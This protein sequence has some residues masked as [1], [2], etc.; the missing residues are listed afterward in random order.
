MSSNDC[1]NNT[2]GD[3]S[4][5]LVID[6]NNNNQQILN[7][8]DNKLY[9]SLCI[10]FGILMAAVSFG[11]GYTSVGVCGLLL[12]IGGFVWYGILDSNNNKLRAKMRADIA[13]NTPGP[14]VPL[15]FRQIGCLATPHPSATPSPQLLAAIASATLPPS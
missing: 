12:F 1:S 6:F 11:N 4:N 5:N 14:T 13:L 10:G 7:N 8:I 2:D 15:E 3:I 9:S